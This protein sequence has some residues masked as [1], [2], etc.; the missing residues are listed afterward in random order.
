MI[1]SNYR[2]NFEAYIYIQENIKRDTTLIKL[3]KEGRRDF[4]D[5]KGYKISSI[6]ETQTR[7]REIEERNAELCNQ[8]LREIILM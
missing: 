4:S 1:Y 7:E 2:A 3:Y 5:Y 8:D 6:K